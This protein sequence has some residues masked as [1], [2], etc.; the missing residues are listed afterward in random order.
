[1]GDVNS[2]LLRQRAQTICDYRTQCGQCVITVENRLSVITGAMR[3][4]CAYGR[5]HRPP[6]ITRHRADSV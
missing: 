5:E 2:V 6:V 3:T 1:M 4:V